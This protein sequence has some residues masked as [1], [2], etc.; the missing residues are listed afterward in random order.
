M[1][2]EQQRR[3]TKLPSSSCCWMWLLLCYLKRARKLPNLKNYFDIHFVGGG[4][5]SFVRCFNWKN[6]LARF[7]SVHTIKV[8][9]TKIAIQFQ[10][11][12][13]SKS[14][15]LTSIV[16]ALCLNPMGLGLYKD[17]AH[18]MAKN[19]NALTWKCDILI[20]WAKPGVDVINKF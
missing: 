8:L 20:K 7:G 19:C 14:L 16:Q 10:F 17:W 1:D 5:Q 18:I 6:I 3:L 15:K 13:N 12:S 9:R 2:E 11:Q 4:R